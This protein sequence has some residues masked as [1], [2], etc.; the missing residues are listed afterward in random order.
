MPTV[1]R[2][3][4]IVSIITGTII[5]FI[6]IAWAINFPLQ[7]QASKKDA[8]SFIQHE[9]HLS[10]TLIKSI[11]LKKDYVVNGYNVIVQFK[12]DSKYYYVYERN[13]SSWGKLPYH[14]YLS[15]QDK[16][17]DEVANNAKSIKHPF[18]N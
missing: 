7:K 17:G 3:H 14:T 15:I 13:M 1:I 16:N 12:D 2:S 8:I 9:Q 5:L 18:A 6:G 11:K 10:P 4:K